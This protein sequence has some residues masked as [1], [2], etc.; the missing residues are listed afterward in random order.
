MRPL[1]V[2]CRGSDDGSGCLATAAIGLSCL[3][4][5]QASLAHAQAA[6]QARVWDELRVADVDP[7]R[8]STFATTRFA[9]AGLLDLARVYFFGRDWLRIEGSA[10]AENFKSSEFVF[11]R[12]DYPHEW[13]ADMTGPSR[14]ILRVGGSCR[15]ALTGISGYTKSDETAWLR[16]QFEGCQGCESTASRAA[17][18]LPLQPD[19][20]FD[21]NLYEWMCAIS[22]HAACHPLVAT[23]TPEPAT[24]TPEPT[25]TTT[26]N[27]ACNFVGA[28]GVQ[29]HEEHLGLGMCSPEHGGSHSSHETPSVQGCQISCDLTY[30]EQAVGYVDLADINAHVDKI[31]AKGSVCK[32][33]AYNSD[34]KVCKIF[35]GSAVSDTDSDEAWQCFG[36]VAAKSFSYQSDFS[37]ECTTAPPTFTSTSTTAT[38][39]TVT[40]TT[41]ML[42]ELLSLKDL[43]GVKVEEGAVYG[44][45]GEA[46]FPRAGLEATL[47]QLQSH[48]FEDM[49]YYLLGGALPV[50]QAKWNQVVHLMGEFGEAAAWPEPNTGDCQASVSVD[51]IPVDADF[52][53]DTSST[54]MT[55]RQRLFMSLGLSILLG[56]L[57]GVAA[58]FFKSVVFPDGV[59]PDED[60][61][62]RFGVMIM[63]IFAALLML[64]V[65]FFVGQ[66]LS[67]FLGRV[68]IKKFI[69]GGAADLL[70]AAPMMS[71]LCFPAAVT[72]ACI[73]LVIWMWPSPEALPGDSPRQR[74][75][76][77]EYDSAENS[78]RSVNF[79]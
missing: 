32:G 55:S 61:A 28:V 76:H 51:R 11:K 44:E 45:P 49:D 3:L 65:I 73:T 52:K 22:D 5:L 38:T 2:R 54:S 53:E 8:I 16:L 74:H 59:A 31:N 33:Y 25:T 71:D 4:S 56:V 68:A 12:L 20:N 72:A 30:T 21:S 29:T 67:W 23:T 39:T 7:N 63:A 75:I 35:T 50:H 24:T 78:L 10:D 37:A 34:T 9:E 79:S 64:P 36:N 42:V 48:C 13:S 14:V 66:I 62:S 26:P 15:C 77:L 69:H 46:H 19:A 70:C 60:A 47:L 18:V 27:P 41:T 6:H 58:M 57:C 43:F 1:P 17:V 40:T